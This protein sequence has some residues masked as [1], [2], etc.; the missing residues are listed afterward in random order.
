[1]DRKQLGEQIRT[2]MAYSDATEKQIAALEHVLRDGAVGAALPPPV[3]FDSGPMYTE[4]ALVGD[5]LARA[6]SQLQ[7]QERQLHQALSLLEAE[8]AAEAVIT[9]MDSN[10]LEVHLYVTPL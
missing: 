4:I 1:M 9:A 6:E 10:A 3:E 2:V 5:R 8:E 7:D